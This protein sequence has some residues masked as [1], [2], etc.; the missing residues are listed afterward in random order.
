MSDGEAKQ[1]QDPAS[2]EATI[3]ALRR[4]LRVLHAIDEIRARHQDEEQGSVA[5]LYDAVLQSGAA[6]RA[7]PRI[8]GGNYLAMPMRIEGELV[9]VIGAAKAGGMRGNSSPHAGSSGPGSAS[10][11]AAT[12]PL[13]NEP[14]DQDHQGPQ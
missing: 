11:L 10:P 14:D 12:E 2:A 13:G 4:Q 8:F 5:Q 9:G 3:R 7:D 6:V 1:A